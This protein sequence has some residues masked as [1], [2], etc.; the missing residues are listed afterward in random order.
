MFS[1]N[2]WSFLL[3]SPVI[4][5]VKLSLDCSPRFGDKPIL[6]SLSPKWDCG[7]KKVNYYIYTF[8]VPCPPAN[9]PFVRIDYSKYEYRIWVVCHEKR[10]LIY[11]YWNLH[12]SRG[13]RSKYRS[14]AAKVEFWSIVRC[15]RT[16]GLFLS[17]WCIF[18]PLIFFHVLVAYTLILIA[19]SNLHFVRNLALL[20]IGC[21]PNQLV[22]EGSPLY[23]LQHETTY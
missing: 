10:L 11:I 15:T 13:T 4:V 21:L 22:I 16:I 6:S 19:R 23:F 8:L 18:T 3:R 12:S 2:I 9:P 20:M 14:N 5:F 17:F 1:K 7:P